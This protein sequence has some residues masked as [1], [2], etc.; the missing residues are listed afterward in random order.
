MAIG[1]SRR[2]SRT[3]MVGG[4]PIGGAS[5]VSV[6][7]MTNTDTHDVPATL[8]AVRAL[9]D[10]GCDIVRLAVPDL[11]AARTFASNAASS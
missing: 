5:S 1:M 9:A 8:R 2:V 7:S 10:A 3:V 4:V 11:A 6:Q